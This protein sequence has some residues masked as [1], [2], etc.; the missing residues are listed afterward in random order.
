[1]PSQVSLP[2]SSAGSGPQSP[3]TADAFGAT[4]SAPHAKDEPRD[5]AAPASGEA[6][7]D[8]AAEE[9]FGSEDNAHN[10]AGLIMSFVASWERD[11][12]EKPPGVWLANEFRQYPQIRTGG[13]GTNALRGIKDIKDRS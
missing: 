8:R 5:G 10:T 2:T 13:E 6:L 3:S 1:M 9:V 7:A 12:H 4:D 11:K